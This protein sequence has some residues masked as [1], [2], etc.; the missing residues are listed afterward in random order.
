MITGTIQAVGPLS[1]PNQTGVSYQSITVVDAAGQSYTHDIGTKQQ[2][3]YR[4]GTPITVDIMSNSRGQY[5][6]RVNPQFAQ[7]HNQYG[8]P[9]PPQQGGYQ[10]APQIAP[11]PV[12]QVQQW[13]P[14]NGTAEQICFCQ[15][16]NLA[17][18]AYNAGAIL[19]FKQAVTDF[20][21]LLKN[22]KFAAWMDTSASPAQ[23]V[24]QTDNIDDDIPF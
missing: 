20:Y 16:V 6:K 18:E 9:A 3:G 17:W 13:Q 1:Q 10:P 21:D 5:F 7:N 14:T 15:A 12:P 2:G 22:R 19:V 8:N 11:Q 4:P 24:A 23:P